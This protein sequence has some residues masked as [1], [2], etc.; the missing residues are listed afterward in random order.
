MS[1]E[2]RDELP[3]KCPPGGVQE[4]AAETTVYRIVRNNPPTSDD[5]RSQRQEQPNAAF[6]VDECLARGLSVWA[7]QV[8]AAQRLR[9]PKFRNARVC[10]LKLTAGAGKIMQ[11][12]KPEHRT[13]WPYRTYDPTTCCEVV[14]T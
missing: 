5:F 3:E 2:F 12:F 4:I 9:L 1:V 11:T 6:S 7:D 13:W 10:R 14:A 8:A